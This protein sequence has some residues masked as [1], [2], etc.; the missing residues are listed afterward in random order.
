MLSH[1]KLKNETLYL[2]AS[3]IAVVPNISMYNR[4]LNWISGEFELFL[5]DDS[6]GLKVYFPSG[7]LSVQLVQSVR[8]D[9]YFEIHVKSKNKFLG[10]QMH[11]Q[12]LVVLDQIY[13]V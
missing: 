8:S 5:Q 6:N 9:V 10:T 13:K 12:A 7:C 2:E 3:K 11:R 1:Y 4:F